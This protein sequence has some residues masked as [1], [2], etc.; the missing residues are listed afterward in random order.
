MRCLWAGRCEPL[1]FEVTFGMGKRGRRKRVRA[2]E[3]V[4]RAQA[5]VRR[6]GAAGAAK[7]KKDRNTDIFAIFDRLKDYE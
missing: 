5:E 2:E 7:A 1:L 3:E 4:E 6:G